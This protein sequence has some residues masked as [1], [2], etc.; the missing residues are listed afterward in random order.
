LGNFFVAFVLELKMS[1]LNKT[2]SRVGERGHRWREEREKAEIRN[3]ID[4]S[5]VTSTVED[6][7][8]NFVITL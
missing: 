8:K 7:Y 5:T 4:V 6:C 2:V 1:T 3:G